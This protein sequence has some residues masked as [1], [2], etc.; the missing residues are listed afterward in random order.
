MQT[1][2]TRANAI[3]CY[4]LVVLA[5]LTALNVA[6]SYLFTPNPKVDFAITSIQ[7]FQ[8]HPTS[9]NDILSL[10]FDLKADLTSL[11]HWNTKQL[12]VYISAQYITEKNVVNQMVL[13]DDVIVKDNLAKK[14]KLRYRD[15]RI[16]Y[17]LVD[18]GHGLR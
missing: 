12:F 8:R 18:Q 6:T 11:F 1:W 2:L 7:L 5:V 14:A 10:T 3:L 9:Q 17:M 16:E 15:T 4:A 13:W